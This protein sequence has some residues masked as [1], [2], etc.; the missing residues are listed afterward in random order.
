MKSN[1]RLH[2][3]HRFE[4]WFCLTTKNTKGT[5]KKKNELFDQGFLLNKSKHIPPVNGE[6]VALF[7]IEKINEFGLLRKTPGI[8]FEAPD[9]T[10]IR[11]VYDGT[12]L[13]A[14]YLRG[15]GN[16]VILDHGYQYYTIISRIE[17]ILAAKGDQL[18]RDSIIGI[19]GATA[20]L[21]D[22]GL[23]FE[24]RHREKSLDPLEWLDK[25]LLVFEDGLQL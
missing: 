11:A 25:D 24:I 14:G 16:T 13:F 23:Y 1:H 12:V 3:C 22:K 9:G 18:K 21:L 6:I 8:S 10:K 5:K 2:R 7:N 17:R 20:T 19:M 4:K 15:Y